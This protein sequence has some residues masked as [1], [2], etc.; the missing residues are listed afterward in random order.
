MEI[1][2]QIKKYRSELKL[3]QE[4]LAEK[5]FVTRQTISN[6]ENEKNYPDIKSLLMLSSLFGISLDILVKGD[7]EEMKEQIKETDIKKFDRYGNI[8]TILLLAMIISPIPLVRYLHVMGIVIWAVLA[9]IT[10]FV[11]NRVE[12]VKKELD[13]QTYREIV[14][15]MN[16]EKLDEI[17]KQKER[18]KL[19]TQRIGLVIGGGVVALV[20]CMVMAV[21]LY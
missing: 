17:E 14:A 10:L 12:K 20:V 18:K 15:F 8:Y 6:W 13:I 1:G 3:S 7:I 9:V 11:A 21:L 4:Q 16:G 5:I 2:N 19:R